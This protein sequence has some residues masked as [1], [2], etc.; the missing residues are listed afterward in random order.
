MRRRKRKIPVQ[1]RK[2]YKWWIKN[3]YIFLMIVGVVCLII[4]LILIYE[5][6]NFERT[7]NMEALL[8]K[9]RRDMHWEKGITD[10]DVEVLKKRYP[11]INWETTWDRSRWIGGKQEERER[12]SE[13]KAKQKLRQRKQ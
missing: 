8:Q 6:S 9:S 10:Q 3:N 2:R 7:R 12:R 11:N 4:T 5:V 13:A 1:K